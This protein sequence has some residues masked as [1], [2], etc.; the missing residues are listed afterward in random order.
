MKTRLDFT[1]DCSPTGTGCWEVFWRERDSLVG[2]IEAVVG[3]NY[4]A[5][6]HAIEM[7]IFYPPAGR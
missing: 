4:P 3:L 1:L 2:H 6:I 7:A 5:S